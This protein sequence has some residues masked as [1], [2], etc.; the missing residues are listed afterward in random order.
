MSRCL[1]SKT[2]RTALYI[3]A[4]GK[5]SLCGADLGPDWHAD[6]IIPW[7]LTGTTNVH[8]MQALCPGCNLKKGSKVGVELNLRRHQKESIEVAKEMRER[9]IVG[10]ALSAVFSIVPGGGKSLIPPLMIKN[11]PGWKVAWFV[12]RLALRYQAELG[13]LRDFGG[14]GVLL[15]GSGNDIDPT[16]GHRGFVA[17]HQALMKN[18]R[19]WIDEL[20]REKYLLVIDEVHHA[21]IDRSGELTALA[22]SIDALPYSGRVL[23]T[24]TLDTNDNTKIYGV[25]YDCHG[26]LCTPAVDKSKF[27]IQYT[28]SDAAEEGAIVPVKIF[29]HDGHVRWTH[30]EMLDECTLS[31]ASRSQ[32]A[33]AV[34]TA[35]NSKMANE[36]LSM[37]FRHYKQHG[38]KLLIVCASQSHAKRFADEVRN[39]MPTFLAISDNET[40]HADIEKFKKTKKSCLVTCQMAY[41]GL[42]DR[43][44][45]HIACLTHIRSAPWIEQML[46]RA[47]RAN[48]EIG[49]KFCYAFVPADPQ[50]LR[51]IEKIRLE[52][53]SLISDSVMEKEPVATEKSGELSL[54]EAVSGAVSEIYEMSLDEDGYVRRPYVTPE[55][56]EFLDA[57]SKLGIRLDDERVQSLIRDSLVT[58]VPDQM[59]PSDI[60]KKLRNDICSICNRKD[61][62]RSSPPDFGWH[63]SV[64][65]RITGKSIKDMNV[66]E[67]ENAHRIS[68]RI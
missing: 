35:L 19:L 29:R 64:L 34:F 63:L 47:W 59:T 62:L 52:N 68:Q 3:H 15:R 2:L 33:K 38:E 45:T 44:I 50:M 36:I 17:T 13:T 61:S 54:T 55:Q 16:R 53:P 1:R 9:S 39:L 4:D 14:E 22:R 20:S 24:G 57:A 42:D 8:E 18:T 25:D 56:Q 46:A 43:E 67:L 48:P 7:C 31:N 49:K 32:E 37:A 10:E 58:S 65:R 21:K 28:R 40:A 23:M 41:E 12:P 51:V 27:N 66:Q 5:C 30:G 6:H 26:G 60:E 11:L